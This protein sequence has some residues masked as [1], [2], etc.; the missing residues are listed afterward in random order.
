MSYI[1][2]YSM[3]SY[4]MK[5]GQSSK[6]ATIAA[7]LAFM[8]V[9]FSAAAQSLAVVDAGIYNVC[10]SK[11]MIRIMESGSIVVDNCGIGLEVTVNAKVTGMAGKRVLCVV[12]PLAKDG[13]VLGDNVGEAMSVVAFNVPTANYSQKLVV[14]LPYQW[15]VTENAKNINA[16]KLGVSLLCF[17]NDMVVEKVFDLDGSKIKIDSSKINGKLMGD[18]FGGMSGADILG[19]LFGGSDVTAERECLSCDGY[20]ICPFCDGEGFFD[21]SFCRK[22]SKDPGI[23]RRCKGE[24]VETV[25]YDIN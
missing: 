6:L 14:P 11:R 12:N 1:K 9:S 23:C 13:S 4:Q 21:P 18:M 15:V 22:C 8:F 5:F 20:K 2:S 17:E 7:M 3:K 19:G 24:G 16:V 10:M 25:N